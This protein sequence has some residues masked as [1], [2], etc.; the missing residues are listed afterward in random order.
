MVSQ[1]E[2]AINLIVICTAFYC[3]LNQKHTHTKFTFCKSLEGVA[4]NKLFFLLSNMQQKCMS[5]CK[6][7]CVL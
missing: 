7:I 2:G 3:I 6:F 4:K 1:K 5:L